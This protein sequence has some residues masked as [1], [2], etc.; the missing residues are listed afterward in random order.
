MKRGTF[1]LWWALIAVVFCVAITVL[2][3]GAEAS[4]TEAID[5]TCR[6]TAGGSS[7]GT[8]CVFERSEG[9][10]FVLTCAHVVGGSSLVECE[11]WK[12]GHLSRPLAGTVTMRSS[13][14]DAAIIMVPETAFGGAPPVVVPI[15]PRDYIVRPGDM[16]TS[17]GCAN[18]S[19]ST[20]WKGHALGYRGTDLHFMPTPANGRS[21][22]AVFNGDATQIVGLLR[23][24][25]GDDSGSNGIATSIQG[26]HAAF[27]NQAKSPITVRPATYDQ[28]VQCPGG[29]CP[30][31]GFP[32][33]QTTPWRLLPY[34][35]QQDQQG[36]GGQQQQP[37]PV[38]PT[39]PLQPF[40]PGTPP[41]DLGPTNQRIDNLA[42]RIGDLLEEIRRGQEVAPPLPPTIEPP[43]VDDTALKTAEE[44]KA[45]AASAKQAVGTLGESLQGTVEQVGTVSRV[46]E[47]LGGTV[48]GLS[49]AVGNLGKG[50]EALSETVQRI[51]AEDGTLMQRLKARISKAHEEGAEGFREVARSVLLGYLW[52]LGVPL[53]VVIGVLVVVDLWK[54][55]RYGDPLF[56]Q[57]PRMHIQRYREK[58]I[59]G[60]L[61]DVERPETEPG[62]TPAQAKTN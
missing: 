59:I 20:G 61:R 1:L 41:V 50:Q 17:V 13:E 28:I 14:A 40:T 62:K 57:D 7:R 2:A 8:G 51:D 54:K 19:W 37:N 34:R 15:A 45:E 33:T 22:S 38:Y 12:D 21:G 11:F 42:D 5:A 44:A 48:G 3:R 36:G 29:Q 32:G 30:S 58:G 16:L 10:V 18:G 27:G 4:L 49:N 25:T 55:A 39:L 9:R 56:I 6:I 35:H 53:L 43:L 60:G 46:V 31:Q 24:R 52:K 23:A 26:L 47:S